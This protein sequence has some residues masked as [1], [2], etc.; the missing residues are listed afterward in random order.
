MRIDKFATLHRRIIDIAL[1]WIHTD[2]V[3]H[4]AIIILRTIAIDTEQSQYEILGPIVTAVPT[5]AVALD[6]DV[7]NVDNINRMGA[8]MHLFC[9]LS[10]ENTFRSKILLHLKMEV[11]HKIFNA[12]SQNK[13][14]MSEDR[15][16]MYVYGLSLINVLANFDEEWCNYKCKLLQQK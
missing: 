10:K 11:V 12:L 16:N 14:N 3:C 1:K 8:I 9:V 4:R 7:D 6:N 5:L 15:I 13:A 2:S